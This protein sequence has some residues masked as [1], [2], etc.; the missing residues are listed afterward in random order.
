ML[1]EDCYR[2]TESE[3]ASEAE[4][5]AERARVT[6]AFSLVKLPDESLDDG[7]VVSWVKYVLRVVDGFCSWV[8]DHGKDTSQDAL[9]ELI[10][11]TPAGRVRGRNDAKGYD[12]VGVWTRHAVGFEANNRGWIRPPP[13]QEEVLKKRVLAV[14]TRH[15]SGDALPAQDIYFQSDYFK[16][17]LREKI[18][19]PFKKAKPKTTDICYL[20]ISGESL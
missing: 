17:G 14:A 11:K 2:H 8:I 19:L 10:Q 1:I 5:A 16:H 13:Y 12:Y 20:A 7:D 6:N 15:A 4:V 9:A 18:L 3:G